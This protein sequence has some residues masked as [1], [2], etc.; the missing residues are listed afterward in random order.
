MTESIDEQLVLDQL[1]QWLRDA[2]AE[3]LTPSASSNG[4]HEEVGLYRLVEEF[5]ALR[6]EVKLLT[7]GARGLQEQAEPLLPAL[8]KAIEHLRSLEPPESR[9]AWKAGK[10]LAE[11]LANLDE[12]LVRGRTE[13]EKARSRIVDE[14]HAE[15]LA[16]VDS[17]HAAQSWL[18]RRWTRSYHAVLR[19]VIDQNGPAARRPL[20]AALIE[21]YSL[22]QTRL[23]RV[24]HSEEIERIETIGLPVDPERMTVIELLDHPGPP[25]HVVDELRSGYTWRG[26][27]LRYAEVRA[28]RSIESRFDNLPSVNEQPVPTSESP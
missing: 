6:Q 16:R 7:K 2:H 24:L 15:L 9:A 1:R 10:P 20:F 11:A 4:I 17:A 18:R 25:S 13:L 14:A 28:S 5:T 27:I 21:G 26:R 8:R 22:I 19:D 23:S 3:P 12:A